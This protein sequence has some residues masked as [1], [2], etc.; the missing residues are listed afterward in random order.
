MIVLDAKVISVDADGT[1]LVE[2]PLCGSYHRHKLPVG[3]RKPHCD[4]W[5]LYLSRC[6]RIVMQDG[7][8]HD[9]A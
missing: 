4:R 3:L 2:C 8:V 9:S 1:V 7:A 6:Y 5:D